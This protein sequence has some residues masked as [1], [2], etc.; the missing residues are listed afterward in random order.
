M[1]NSNTLGKMISKR[2]TKYH[3][4]YVCR[5]IERAFIPKTHLDNYYIITN[6]TS[7]ATDLA[8]KF[9]N[10]ILVE[11]NKLLD[12]Y[13]LLQWAAATNTVP[14]KHFVLVFKNN[15]LIEKIC[16]QQ[17]WRL[18]NPSAQLADM[19]EGKITQI[20]WLGATAKKY[21][22]AHRV[23]I[24]EKVQWKQKPFILQFNHSHTGSGTFFI[25]SA[26]TL[27]NLRQQFPKR[28]VRTAQFISGPVFTN[29]NIIWNNN[30]IIG[31]I[32]YQITGLKPFTDNKF[33]TIGNDWALPHILLSKKQLTQYKKLVR[34]IGAKLRANGWK[35]LFGIDVIQDQK[36]GEL[37]LL[38]INARQPASSMLEAWLQT[39]VNPNGNTVFLAHLAALLKI[40]TSDN[41]ITAITD[42]A[43]IVQRVTKK[44]TTAR[45]Q[46]QNQNIINTISYKNIKPGADLLR[47][48]SAQSIM[49]QHNTLN[50][51]GK[52]IR[53]ALC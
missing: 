17:K 32:S 31:N 37:Y 33:S 18:L 51:L 13:E 28:P 41:S 1:V 2:L 6:K 39:R 43:Q 11:N 5:D 24:C 38:E 49:K 23:T 10:I 53:T 8:R 46:L 19:V 25:N 34:A 7:Y 15:A 50:A 35:G 40:K 36:T 26:R 9:S 22:P 21:M 42:G 16:A 52:N 3:L 30:I 14:P 29:N 48:Q 12:T 44:I 45:L 4:F 27:S 20:A 47:V